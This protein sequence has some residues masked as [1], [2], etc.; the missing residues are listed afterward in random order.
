MTGLSKQTSLRWLKYPY[1][2]PTDEAATYAVLSQNP[3]YIR[4]S[5]Y[6]KHTTRYHTM[7]AMWQGDR[8]I[9]FDFQELKVDYFIQLPNAVEI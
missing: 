3:Y 6:N 4:K 7:L 8:F 9:D 1:N 5:G 2:K